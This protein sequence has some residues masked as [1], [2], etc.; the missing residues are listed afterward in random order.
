MKLFVQLILLVAGECIPQWS[1]SQLNMVLCSWFLAAGNGCELRGPRG[2]YAT[3]FYISA[4]YSFRRMLGFL[5]MR[6]V[7]DAFLL[8]TM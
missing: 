5:L 4:S 2:S 3:R 7:R 8:H 1:K 6:S